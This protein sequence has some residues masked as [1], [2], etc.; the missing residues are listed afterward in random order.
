M[1]IRP[2]LWSIFPTKIYYNR[3]RQ[4]ESIQRKQERM[5][6]VNQRIISIFFLNLNYIF[7][8]LFKKIQVKW[9]RH[10]SNIRTCYNSTKLEVRHLSSLTPHTWILQHFSARNQAWEV[11][12]RNNWNILYRKV[13]LVLWF[14]PSFLFFIC[15]G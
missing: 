5:S 12:T 7:L 15:K 4:H 10:K 8:L 6:M 2:M 11:T 13:E 9:A 1:K 3:Q 14:D